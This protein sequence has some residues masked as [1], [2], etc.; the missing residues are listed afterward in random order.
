MVTKG[1]DF[2]GVSIVGILNA[3]NMINFP[4]FRA[5]ERAFN[6]MEQVSG[7]AGRK[8]KQ[9]TV[10]IQTSEPEHPVIK[11]VTEH[12]YQGYYAHEQ[13]ERKAFLYPPFTRIIDIY[14]KHRNDA[15]LTE[16]TTI[17]CNT[18]RKIFGARVLGPQ[19][20]PIARIQQQYIRKITLKMETQASMQKV[21]AILQQIYENSLSDNRMKSAT[22]YYDVDP[23]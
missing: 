22:I 10:C 21:K 7:R 15:S 3:D 16:I 13:E 6:M 1:L 9:G 14:L 23:S 4:D 5:H 18:L 8:H 19:T 20:P 17:Y 2:D 11:F 12:D